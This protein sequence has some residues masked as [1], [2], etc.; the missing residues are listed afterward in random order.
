[1]CRRVRETSGRRHAGASPF[2]W[3][4]VVVWDR[5]LRKVDKKN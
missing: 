1:M 4:K 3:K 5:I 2:F